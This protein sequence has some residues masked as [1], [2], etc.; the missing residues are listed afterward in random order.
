[1]TGCHGKKGKMQMDEVEEKAGQA[2]NTKSKH[3]DNTKLSTRNGDA[4]STHEK[5]ER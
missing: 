1:M 3:G 2:L 4:Q 5:S